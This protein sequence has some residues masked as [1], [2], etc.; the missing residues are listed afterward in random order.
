MNT[1][2]TPNDRLYAILSYVLMPIVSAIVLLS[3][4]VKDR[5]YP[6]FHAIQSLGL[7]AVFVVYSILAVIIYTCGTVFTAGIAGL[8][9]WIIFFVPIPVALYYAY[10]ASQ[11]RYFEIPM[12]TQFMVQQGWLNRA[13][14]L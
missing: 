3:D 9:L 10:V 5:P 12:L 1:E 7:F 13:P 4:G 11:N 14:G 6:R 8:C 2:I